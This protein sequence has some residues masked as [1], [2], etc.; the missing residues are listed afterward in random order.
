[1]NGSIASIGGAVQKDTEITVSSE[2]DI[3]ITNHLKYAAYTPAQGTPGTVG[4]IPPNAT[5]EKNLLGLVCWS[6]NVRIGTSAP[7]DRV[8]GKDSAKKPVSD[9]QPGTGAQ[10]RKN[11]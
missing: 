6:G 1:M 5:G 10:K 8:K 4:Y 9:C 7:N 2:S 11:L 3:I